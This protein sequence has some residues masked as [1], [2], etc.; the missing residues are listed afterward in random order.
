MAQFV[1]KQIEKIVK[2]MTTEGR[3]FVGVLKSFD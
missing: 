1:E 2:V 3:I